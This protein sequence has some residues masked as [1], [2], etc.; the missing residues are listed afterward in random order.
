MLLQNISP[1]DG[2]CNG[3]KLIFEKVLDNKLLVYKFLSSDKRVLI[4]RIKFISDP[5]FYAF[6]WSRRQFPIIIAF[7]TTINKPQ[8]QTL[9]NVGVWL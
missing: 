4:P 6:K 7:A 5:K 8:G 9:K 1:K 2:L 3:T